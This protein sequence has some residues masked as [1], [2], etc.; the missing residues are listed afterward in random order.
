MFTNDNLI[1]KTS[2]GEFVPL[3]TLFIDWLILQT[4][5]EGS[6]WLD[7]NATVFSVLAFTLKDFKRQELLATIC[8]VFTFVFIFSWMCLIF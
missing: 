7:W 8:N 1:W 6:I 4:W 5:I 3:Y 2:L